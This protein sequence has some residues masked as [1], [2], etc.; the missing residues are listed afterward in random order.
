MG[1]TNIASGNTC[2]AKFHASEAS[3]SEE[4]DFFGSNPGLL[5]LALSAILFI[6][7]KTF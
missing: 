5:F 1:L 4:K 3:S 6:R 2:H 7:A